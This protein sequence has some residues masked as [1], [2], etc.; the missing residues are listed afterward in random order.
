MS[1]FLAAALLAAGTA[2][3]AAEAPP[4]P[5]LARVVEKGERLALSDFTTAPLPATVAHSAIPAQ[6]AAGKEAVRRLMAGSTVR[7]GDIASPRVVRR[8]EAVTIAVQSGALLITS[9][10]R[11]LSDGAQ[12]EPVRVL[13]LSTNRTLDAVADKPG[14]VLISVR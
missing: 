1:M 5:V 8:G 11:A 10:G 12:G 7:A 9:A 4:V 6:E 13:N 14:Q 3:P 2:A